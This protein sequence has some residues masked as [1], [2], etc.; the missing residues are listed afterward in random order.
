MLWHRTP[1]HVMAT[2]GLRLLPRN[3]SAAILDNCR[4]VL[5]ASGFAF[6]PSW[7]RVLSGTEEGLFAW[8]A[9][10]YAAGTLQVRPPGP[11]WGRKSLCVTHPDD[12][13]MSCVTRDRVIRHV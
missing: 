10:N 5:A 2:A 4:A 12:F 11:V 7:A 6:K 8:V 3:Q 1:V 13:V 9:V